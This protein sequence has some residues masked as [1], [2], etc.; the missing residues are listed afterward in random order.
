MSG[1]P[2]SVTF[3]DDYT[4]EPHSRGVGR[5]GTQHHAPEKAR[6]PWLKLARFGNARTEK[7]SLHHDR[8]VIVCSCV[9]AYY[10]GER[11]SKPSRRSRLR[12]SSTPSLSYHRAAS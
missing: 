6:P 4:G 11:R 7:G 2:V 5:A 3:F 9:E 12:R 10:D 1:A 8:K